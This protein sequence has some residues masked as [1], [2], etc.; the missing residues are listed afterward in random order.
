MKKILLSSLIASLLVTGSFAKETA[1]KGATVKQVN[2]I[3]INNAKEEVS[4]HAVKVVQEAVDSLKYA[5]NA[6]VALDK[7]N[8]KEATENLEKALGKLEVTLASKKVPELL[9]VDVSITIDEFIGS[10]DTIKKTVKLAKD[11][12]DENKVQEAK[13][14]LAPLKSE[15]VTSVVNLP[16]ATYPTALKETAKRIHDDKINEAKALLTTTLHT[17]VEVDTII[18]LPLV[19]A[20]DLI[21]AAAKVAE[22]NTDQAIVYLDAAK[23]E[24]KIARYLGY[25]SKSD[26]TYKALD[27]AIDAL[28]L[29]IK[30]KEVKA[31]FTKLQTKIKDFTSKIFSSKE[32][33]K[34]TTK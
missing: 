3:A 23:E 1:P 20:T 12:L 25:V 6:L 21:D 16:L 17:F 4:N 29:D 2:T 11:L 15:I 32:K 13:E 24:L 19:K 31:L 5:Y 10:S 34:D 26:V 8:K 27:D 7:G 33:A 14:V 18:P 28:K 30:S 22:E 9:P